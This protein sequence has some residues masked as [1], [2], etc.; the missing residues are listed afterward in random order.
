LHM[1]DGRLDFAAQ[2]LAAIVESSEDPILSKNLEGSITSWNQA[3]ERVFG[4][5]AAEAVG[6]PSTI[7]IPEDRRE[8]ETSVLARIRNNESVSHFDTVRRHKD[9]SLLDVATTIS[10]IR[11]SQG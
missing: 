5:T 9:G 8:E 7:I 4:Y 1:P 11:D 10:P 6:Q 3:A 2:R